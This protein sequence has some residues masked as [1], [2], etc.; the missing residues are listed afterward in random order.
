MPKG[1]PIPCRKEFLQIARELRLMLS[2]IN[3]KLDHLIERYKQ[4]HALSHSLES[5][6]HR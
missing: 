6:F 5:E 1:K 4:F 2:D 3:Q